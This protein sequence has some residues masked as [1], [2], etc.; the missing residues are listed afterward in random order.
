[1]GN[2]ISLNDRRKVTPQQN[3]RFAVSFTRDG[4]RWAAG[5]D[6]NTVDAPTPEERLRVMASALIEFGIDVTRMADTYEKDPDNHERVVCSINIHHDGKIVI[7]K[8]DS[9]FKHMEDIDWLA[10][11]L[12]IATEGVL[13]DLTPSE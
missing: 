7:R 10:E 1:M 11:R 5:I 2:V 4:D 9:E 8:D 6:S 12:T 3:E 13:E